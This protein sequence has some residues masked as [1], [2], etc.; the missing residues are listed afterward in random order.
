[1]MTKHS[2]E[3]SFLAFSIMVAT[4]ILLSSFSPL[5]LASSAPSAQPGHFPSSPISS[6]SITSNAPVHALSGSFSVNITPSSAKLDVG[7]SVTFSV[8][9]PSS[10]FNYAWYVN[11]VLSGSNLPTFKFTPSN[12]GTYSI[13]VNVTNG[14]KQVNSNPA[15][16]TVYGA[17]SV[18]ISPMS[19][20][21]YVGQTVS[22]TSTVT[23]GT[24]TFQYLWYL[25]GS[26]T[27]A[28]TSTY[29]LTPAGNATYYVY[30]VVNDTGT[31]NGVPA[32]PTAQSG[33]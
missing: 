7:Q 31:S 4:V 13:Y 17:L 9:N 10:S 24:G 8:V 27:T 23:G 16:V 3:R 29:S 6:A 14:T 1:M 28:T 30:L 2:A 21:V 18:T 22:F 32:T 33:R 26:K 15:T 5:A 11:G 20:K 12:A 25:N 19:Q